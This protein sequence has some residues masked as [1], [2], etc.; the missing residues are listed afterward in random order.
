ME[1]RAYPAHGAPEGAAAATRTAAQ[2]EALVLQAERHTARI[3]LAADAGAARWLVAQAQAASGLAEVA[4][5]ARVALAADAARAAAARREA[6]PVMDAFET[7]AA[8]QARAAA[9]AAAHEAQMRPIE[10]AR[11]VGTALDESLATV[12]GGGP[13]HSASH[14]LVAALAT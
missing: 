3:S 4:G 6:T 2:L 10:A 7:A 13:M 5:A 11:A 9:V 8:E 1:L 12:R 14:P